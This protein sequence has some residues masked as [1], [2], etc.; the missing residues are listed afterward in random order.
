MSP[1]VGFPFK[2]NEM[3]FRQCVESCIPTGANWLGVTRKILC[4]NL[5][6]CNGQGIVGF[7]QGNNSGTIDNCN[8]QGAATGHNLHLI[9]VIALSAITYSLQ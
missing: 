1:D 8:N 9:S 5:D 4:C 3:V 2:G 7:S 6:F